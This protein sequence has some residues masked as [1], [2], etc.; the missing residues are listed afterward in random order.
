MFYCATCGALF[1]TVQQ[2]ALH[3]RTNCGGAQLA[4]ARQLQYAPSV[5]PNLH[6]GVYPGDFNVLQGDACLLN[7]FPGAVPAGA[8]SAPVY[9]G[10]VDSIA[11]AR[12][13]TAPA[14]AG[15]PA[16]YS[17]P[18]KDLYMNNQLAQMAIRLSR[19]QQEV[20]QLRGELGVRILPPPSNEYQDGAGQVALWNN[21]Q[22]Q[23]QSPRSRL[24]SD[25]R[26][27]YGNGVASAPVAPSMSLL[28]PNSYALLLDRVVGVDIQVS[29][30]DVV[31]AVDEYHLL[32]G[33]D[34]QLLE[35][36]RQ[37]CYFPL[38]VQKEGF[39]QLAVSLKT[40]FDFTVRRSNEL[41]VFIITFSCHDKVLFWASV[42]ARQE[43]MWIA[44]LR[45]PPVDASVALEVAN[46][47]LPETML[48][49]TI[50][51]TK[52]TDVLAAAEKYLSN[53]AA[54][55]LIPVGKG[56]QSSSSSSGQLQTPAEEEEELQPDMALVKS[57]L[58]KLEFDDKGTLIVPAKFK[59]SAASHARLGKL[60]QELDMEA[61]VLLQVRAENAPLPPRGPAGHGPNNDEVS[62]YVSYVTGL[63]LNAAY[64]RAL[65]Y[66]IEHVDPN[67]GEV[68]SNAGS[69]AVLLR[70]PDAIQYPNIGASAMF[71][72][73]KVNMPSIIVT[74]KT[75]ALVIVEYVTRNEVGPCVFGHAA[76]PIH[77]NA[78]RGNFVSRMRLGDPRRP[79]ARDVFSGVS[80]FAERKAMKQYSQ[81]EIEDALNSQALYELLFTPVKAHAGCCP[82]GYIM[83]CLDSDP[84][85]PHFDFPREPRPTAAERELYLMR[86]KVDQSTLPSFNDWEEAVAA[87][88]GSA[89]PMG[90]R[91]S[92]VVPYSPGRGFYLDVESLHGMGTDRAL[93]AVAVDL[94]FEG[95]EGITQALQRDW[96]SDAG[97]PQ[98]KEP[99]R[100][101]TLVDYDQYCTVIFYLLKVSNLKSVKKQ[102]EKQLTVDSVGWTMLKL[103]IEGDVLRHGRYALPWFAGLPPP[104]M[105]DQLDSEPIEKVFSSWFGANKLRFMESKSTV[106]VSISD[107]ADVEQIVADHPARP[108]P[109]KLFVPA[110]AK[111]SYPA[112]VHEGAVGYTQQRLVE[113]MGL[114]VKDVDLALAAC[115]GAYIKENLRD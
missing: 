91:I 94:G 53:A 78:G 90:N 82:C 99:L 98:F 66:L 102:G 30:E 69:P 6:N 105:M 75:H 103:L 23:Q 15:P 10:G 112:G 31:V 4:Y 9:T 56:P 21:Q 42:C 51:S 47:S 45:Q 63:P 109:A 16:G 50:H 17:L 38:T 74:E 19:A 24:S 81:D 33:I 26:L 35:S 18:E 1:A 57:R 104:E 106:V 86:Q 58:W 5:V 73:F 83:W 93:Y 7:P 41:H 27:G 77:K 89:K 52:A 95:H 68:M 40:P 3:Q 107:A 46:N 60:T 12:Q 37:R 36:I 79:A 85:A 39:A 110:A 108:L 2:L 22:L 49:G 14:I 55:R 70:S 29:L 13:L 34:Q 115:V 80:L 54:L 62:F 87:F 72:L 64:S 76:L 11:L 43:G 65:V 113:S 59:S 97:A 44:A 114:D 48:R 88:G 92:R 32:D 61:S 25:W 101:L 20:A 67:T 111:E 100:M 28:E 84:N 96:A 8:L 71:P